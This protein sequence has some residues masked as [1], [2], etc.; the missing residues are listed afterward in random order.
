MSGQPDNS[1]SS[2]KALRIGGVV[3]TVVIIALLL[4]W[5]AK[6]KPQPI[7][8][9]V[10]APSAT[11]T[12]A[13]PTVIPTVRVTAIATN[14]ATT[15]PPPTKTVAPA[16]STVVPPTPTTRPTPTVAP[17]AVIVPTVMPTAVPVPT[18]EPTVEPVVVP[19]PLPNL[20]DT[21]G[22]GKH[23]CPTR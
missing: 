22:G 21:G 19:T 9:T 17:T 1:A 15:V 23:N 13:A 5:C 4:G 6:P 7:Q 14:P 16:T 12:I 20:P 18:E 11:A 8:P 3:V 10:V 2:G